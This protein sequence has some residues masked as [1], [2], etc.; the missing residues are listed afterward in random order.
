M[1][2]AVALH[3]QVSTSWALVVKVSLLPTQ[4]EMDWAFHEWGSIFRK[5]LV[6][7][8][9]LPAQDNGNFPGLWVWVWVVP[10]IGLKSKMAPYKGCG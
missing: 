2:G 3:Q 4:G 1:G 7:G 10:R 5:S 9:L 8:S 6:E